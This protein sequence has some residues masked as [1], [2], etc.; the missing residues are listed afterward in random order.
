MRAYKM[1]KLRRDGT[2]GPPFIHQALRIPLGVR[3]EAEDHKTAG[4][5]HR[6]GWHCFAQPSAPHL[7]ARPN[8]V[9]CEV[10]VEDYTEHHRPARYGGTMYLARYLTVV[11]ILER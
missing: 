3:L 5:V 10:E 4:Y 9:W 8:R 11:R 6:P 2:L 1:L 7:A